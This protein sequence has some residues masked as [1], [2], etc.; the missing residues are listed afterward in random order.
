MIQGDSATL[1]ARR[2]DTRYL[3]LRPS[4]SR[5]GVVPFSFF[6]RRRSP[7]PF[8]FTSPRIAPAR[9]ESSDEP[10]GHQFHF[11]KL[12]SLQHIRSGPRYAPNAGGQ[13]KNCWKYGVSRVSNV[14]EVLPPHRRAGLLL[15]RRFLESWCRGVSGTVAGGVTF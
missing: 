9:R 15:E 7:L 4:N 2:R 13:V 11:G 3:D 8:V 14:F 6:P 10:L 12:S 1:L 5:R